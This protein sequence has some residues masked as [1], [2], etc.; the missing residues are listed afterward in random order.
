MFCSSHNLLIWLLMNR[1]RCPWCKSL[2]CASTLP[3]TLGIF[4]ECSC[5][6]NA[7]QHRETLQRLSRSFASVFHSSSI[8][9]G[10]SGYQMNQTFWCHL[11]L[12]KEFLYLDRGTYGKTFFFPVKTLSQGCFDYAVVL[13][14]YCWRLQHTQFQHLKKTLHMVTLKGTTYH[15][16]SL[17]TT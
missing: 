8:Y 3:T 1:H 12:F 16:L 17:M 10:F 5:Y 9:E 4:I 6:K 15:I 11:F 14:L 13:V 2:I 7:V